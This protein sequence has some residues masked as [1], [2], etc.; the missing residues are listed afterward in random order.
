MS[1]IQLLPKEQETVYFWNTVQGNPFRWKP[2]LCMML[3]PNGIVKLI[4]IQ[5][6]GMAR[7]GDCEVLIKFDKSYVIE[8]LIKHFFEPLKIQDWNFAVA[9]LKEAYD[10]YMKRQL[11][12][13]PTEDDWHSE[14]CELAGIDPNKDMNTYNRTELDAYR[15][16]AE[17]T[18]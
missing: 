16:I 1:E 5:L 6:K 13:V 15:R 8:Y 14:I 11:H 12:T 7:T 10:I 18:D 17:L 4:R 3:L 9:I 2:E